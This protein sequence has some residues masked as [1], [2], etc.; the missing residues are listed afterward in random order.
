MSWPD[1]RLPLLKYNIDISSAISNREDGTITIWRGDAFW[2]LVRQ[3]RFVHRYLRPD[4][5][6]VTVKRAAREN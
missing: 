6:R 4:Y 5:I 2:K 1:S 3:Y